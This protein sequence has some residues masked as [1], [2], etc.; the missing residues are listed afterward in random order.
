MDLSPYAYDHPVWWLYSLAL[1]LCV[2][3]DARYFRIPNALVVTIALM[4]VVMLGLRAPELLPMHMLVAAIGFGI[5]Y[6]LF[7]FA[8]M[9]AGDAKLI[10][11]ILLWAGLGGVPSLMVWFSI[12][13]LVLVLA[14]GMGRLLVPRLISVENAWKVF[15]KNGPI[16][17]ATAIGPAAI[18]ASSSFPT[19]LWAVS[20]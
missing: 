2:C 11:A 6:V 4:A 16:P 7:Q 20:G 5:G 15:Q 18:L 3:W 9:G 12:F 10:S 14:I 19:V 17:L 8:A 1:A 13:C